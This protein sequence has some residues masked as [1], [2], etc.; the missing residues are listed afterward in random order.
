VRVRRAGAPHFVIE[1]ILVVFLVKLE[2]VDWFTGKALDYEMDDNDDD[3]E[4]DEEDDEDDFDDE[5]RRPRSSHAHQLTCRTGRRVGRRAAAARRQG[6]R[7]RCG[8]GRGRERRPERVQAAV[9]RLPAPGVCAALTAP[10][11]ES[12]TAL[13]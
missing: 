7:R 3:L 12:L 13:D 6:P 11:R 4:L 2:A 10:R 5:V 8:G 9:K 1:V